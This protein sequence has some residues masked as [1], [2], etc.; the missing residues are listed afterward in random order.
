MSAHGSSK[1]QVLN[2][3]TTRLKFCHFA[4]QPIRI[5]S[6]FREAQGS[7]EHLKLQYRRYALT[8]FNWYTPGAHPASAHCLTHACCGQRTTARVQNS[9]RH[10]H[11]AQ[12]WNSLSKNKRLESSSTKQ[13]EQSRHQQSDQ[14]LGCTMRQTI[15]RV[16]MNVRLVRHVAGYY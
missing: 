4:D 5:I 9:V 2:I 11:A 13:A 14:G 16:S 1:H 10:W 6:W 15:L 7:H 12:I 3:P 8:C